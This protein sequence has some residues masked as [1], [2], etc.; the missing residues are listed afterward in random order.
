MS[1]IWGGGVGWA[2]E[3]IQESRQNFSLEQATK[4]IKNNKQEVIKKF[5]LLFSVSLDVLL[6]GI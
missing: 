2:Q 5:K 6:V 3:H 1:F 4:V